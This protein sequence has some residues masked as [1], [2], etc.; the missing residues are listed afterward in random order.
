[1]LPIHIQISR[2]SVFRISHDF[3]S[4]YSKE[5]PLLIKTNSATVASSMLIINMDGSNHEFVFDEAVRLHSIAV[6]TAC[7]GWYCSS[8]GASVQGCCV[9][10]KTTDHDAVVK[11]VNKLMVMKPLLFTRMYR[12]SPKSFDRTLAIFEGVT[13]KEAEGQ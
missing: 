7:L 8:E 12:L 5:V 1:M 4:Q 6:A 10:C 9:N 3:L 11:K 2:L 13:S